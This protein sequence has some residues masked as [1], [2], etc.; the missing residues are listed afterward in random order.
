MYVPFPCPPKAVHNR[1]LAGV[2]YERVQETEDPELGTK[3]TRAIY[4]AK[5]YSDDWIE[6]RMRAIPRFSLTPA[7]IDQQFKESAE[8][9]KER[10][11][12]LG[13]LGYES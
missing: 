3:R 7:P 5:G 4:N 13:R 9:E 11:K 8:M 6:K 12:G 10:R 1:W 2:D